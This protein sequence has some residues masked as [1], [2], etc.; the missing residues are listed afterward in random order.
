MCKIY[1]FFFFFLL[2]FIFLFPPMDLDVSFYPPIECPTLKLP[3]SFVSALLSLSYFHLAAAHLMAPKIQ[4]TADAS[5]KP[6]PLCHRP[7]GP[8]ISG[9][10]SA[11]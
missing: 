9:W 5:I 7:T 4:I 8:V 1:V 2:H 6:Q 11:H 10:L 3:C